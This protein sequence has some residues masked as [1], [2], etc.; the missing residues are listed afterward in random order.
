VVHPDFWFAWMSGRPTLDVF[1]AESSNTPEAAFEAEKIFSRPAAVEADTLARYGVTH[2]VT[3]SDAAGERLTISPRFAVVW[4]RPPISLL[5]VSARP[6]QPPPSSLLSTG[7]DADGR[8]TRGE[9]EHLVIEADS[10]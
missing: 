7:L 6:G 5:S 9:A 1:N 8:L 4:Q 3:T 2:V 10:S